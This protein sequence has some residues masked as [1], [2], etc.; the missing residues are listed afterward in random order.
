MT[1]DQGRRRD[2]IDR[3]LDEWAHE[4]PDLDVSALAVIGRLSRYAA[5]VQARLDAVFA[6]HG[7]QSWEFDV[8]SALRRSGP[9]YELTPGELDRALLITS[10]T[11]THRVQRLEA[12][13]FVT[14]R[15]DDEDRRVVRVRLTGTGLAAHEAT[16]DAHAANE[17]RILAG[18][19]PDERDALLGGLQALGR[20]LG[21]A[22]DE[23]TA[24]G[25]DAR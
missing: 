22:T 9:P 23:A 12:R 21:D 3:I 5:L 6:E 4:R 10:G 16:H 20:V 15:R 19:D 1:G 25:G 2:A 24:M 17:T 11:T 13:G 14:R 8:L 18:L 7:L